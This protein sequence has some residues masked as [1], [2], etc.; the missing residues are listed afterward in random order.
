[1]KRMCVVAL[2]VVGLLS[3]APRAVAQAMGVFKG[4]L[5]GAAGL[6]ARV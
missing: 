5:T 4:G 6:G 1:M 3:A 2:C